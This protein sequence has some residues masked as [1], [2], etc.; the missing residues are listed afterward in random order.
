MG[1]G[2]LLAMA[3]LD[4]PVIGATR[5]RGANWNQLGRGIIC[6]C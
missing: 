5:I 2:A 3:G 6:M 1:D 4:K